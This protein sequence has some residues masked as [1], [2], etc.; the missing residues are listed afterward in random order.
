MIV[1]VAQGYGLNSY[2]LNSFIRVDVS[3]RLSYAK[4]HSRSQGMG[5]GK[6]GPC[7]KA[8]RAI[9]LHP[10]LQTKRLNPKQGRKSHVTQNTVNIS[11]F[12]FFTS[13]IH[14][15]H[16]VRINVITL[17][18]LL[19]SESFQRNKQRCRQCIICPRFPDGGWQGQSLS[20]GALFTPL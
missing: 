19:A 16:L 3:E 9:S 20:L 18:R 13:S 12:W 2:E 11:L 8:L 10:V 7:L 6:D 4:Y 1:I 5:A 17:M 14:T 15:H